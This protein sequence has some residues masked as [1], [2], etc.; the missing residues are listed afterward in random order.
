V[1]LFKLMLGR[2]LLPAIP[3]RRLQHGASLDEFR[4]GTANLA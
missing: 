3:P 2:L 4:F 1:E